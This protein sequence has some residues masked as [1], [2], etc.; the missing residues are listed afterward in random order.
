MNCR[1]NRIENAAE[2]VTIIENE[3]SKVKEA[4]KEEVTFT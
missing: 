3:F 2:A 1:N 4:L